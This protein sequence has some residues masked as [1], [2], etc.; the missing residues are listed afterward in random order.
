[1]SKRGRPRTFP[2]KMDAQAG[3]RAPEAL[4]D[5]IYVVAQRNNTDVSTIT[6]AFWLRVVRREGLSFSEN[7]QPVE[8]DALLTT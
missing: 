8:D 1:M 2:G 5:A 7:R 3:I 6:R 4:I